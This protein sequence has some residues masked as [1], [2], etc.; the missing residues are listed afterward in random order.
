MQRWPPRRAPS[1]DVVSRRCPPHCSFPNVSAHLLRNLLRVRRDLT[2]PPL[3]AS[4][5][6]WARPYHLSN[7]A[8]IHRLS[9]SNHAS[10]ASFTMLKSGSDPTQ[11]GATAPNRE[12]P[13]TPFKAKA[14][15][16][17]RVW[18]GPH[19]AFLGSCVTFVTFFSLF[20]VLFFLKKRKRKGGGDGKAQYSGHAS[21]SSCWQRRRRGTV[22]ARLLHLHHRPTPRSA[23]QD[24]A[25]RMAVPR[26]HPC[27]RRL[28][29]WNKSPWS[30][31]PRS[32]RRK[33]F[34]PSVLL[35]SFWAP[36]TCATV[37]NP[38]CTAG[39]LLLHM[40]HRPQSRPWDRATRRSTHD[41]GIRIFNK[42][43]SGGRR[44]RTPQPR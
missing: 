44:E 16:S 5:E 3:L 18:R 20:F 15:T 14:D 13:R 34:A 43:Q 38:Q 4:Q 35:A 37:G 8:G 39:F 10:L 17:D 23:S 6:G 40:L 7:T 31:C 28:D 2:N 19:P 29:P 36:P 33:N 42:N 9:W 27:R 22:T 26:K 11:R 1:W 25:I 41:P 21:R 32:F 12:N 24:A 30:R